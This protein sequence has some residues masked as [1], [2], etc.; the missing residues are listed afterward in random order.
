MLLKFSPKNGILYVLSKV[1]LYLANALRRVM[2]AEVPTLAFD[3]VEI[4]ENTSVLHDE[5]IAHRLGLIPLVSDKATEF[6]YS[7]DCDCD[8]F[9][10]K[11]AVKFKLDITNQDPIE[12]LPVTSINITNE[13]DDD[14]Y[15]IRELCQSVI[16]VDLREYHSEKNDEEHDPIT[17][18]KLG[19]GQQLK[20]TALAKKGISKEHAK[21][22]PVSAIGF[23]PDPI[24]TIDEE[25]ALNLTHKQK[26][27]FVN[28][29]PTKVYKIDQQTGQLI[30][31]NPR[32][33]VYCN[34]C[35]MIANEQFEMRNLVSVRESTNKFIITVESTGALDPAKVVT[36]AIDVIIEKLKRVQKALPKDKKKR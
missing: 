36:T 12:A 35:V 13:T 23:Q 1:K 26:E 16:P 32:R 7:R 9:C 21:F 4:Q 33:C 31:D 5:F 14:D 25:E 18:V 17:L 24:I 22:Q 10:G 27:D 2:I 15:T 11:C 30:I 20:F 8:N 19:A 3:F 28:S 34:D 6:R 29:C